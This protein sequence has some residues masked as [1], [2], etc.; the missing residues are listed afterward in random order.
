M[1]EER[2]A[3]LIGCGILFSLFIGCLLIIFGLNLK[4]RTLGVLCMIPFL[5]VYLLH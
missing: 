1:I 4:E 2:I 5:V 3:I